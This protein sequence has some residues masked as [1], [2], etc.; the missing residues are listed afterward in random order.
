[1]RTLLND[2]I[3]TGICRRTWMCIRYPWTWNRH[4]IGKS[5]YFV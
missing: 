2:V 5:W 3:L 1:M 4:G